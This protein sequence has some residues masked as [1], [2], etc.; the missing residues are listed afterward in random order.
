MGEF[1]DEA[2]SV[3]EQLERAGWGRFQFLA[4]AAFVLFLVS[5]GM[6]LVI[7]NIIWQDLPLASWGVEK[8]AA[9]ERSMLVSMAYFGF[10]VGAMIS[11]AA[12]DVVGRRP[13]IFLHG[14][15]FVPSSLFSAASNDLVQLAATRFVVG[16]SMGLVLPCVNSLMAEFSPIAFRAKAVISIPGIAYR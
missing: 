13:L 5:D 7:T 6:E 9:N 4:M 8:D 3:Q 1:K 2:L 14:L 10:V 15:I 12:G 11:A 16:V